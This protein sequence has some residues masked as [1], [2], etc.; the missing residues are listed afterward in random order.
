[1]ATAGAQ[2]V[3]YDF[4]AGSSDFMS[5]FVEEGITGAAY[6]TT[7]GV[8]NSGSVRGGG[9]TSSALIYNMGFANA[10]GAVFTLSLDFLGGNQSVSSSGD[11]MGLGLLTT[12]TAGWE[13][14]NAGHYS[15]R[16]GIRL[17][18]VGGADQTLFRYQRNDPDSAGA[19]GTL[20]GGF[21]PMLETNHWYR[22]VTTY[23]NTGSDFTVSF[24][25]FDIGGTGLDAPTLLGSTSGNVGMA[26]MAA[27][28]TIYLGLYGGTSGGEVT[29]A[30]RLDNFSASVVAVPEPGV[31][32]LL[33]LGAAAFLARRRS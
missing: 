22:F 33:A 28:P 9:A 2:S 12:T 11:V 29:R 5:A 19:G 6:F 7:G 14:F 23:T 17:S 20:L 21:S 1:M 4:N 16:S 18:N 26:G 13:S 3:S 27:A 25:I 32:A 30:Q 31:I 15:Y 10:P 8:S 24:T